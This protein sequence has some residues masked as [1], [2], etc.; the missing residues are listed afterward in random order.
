MSWRDILPIHP[1]ADALPL[2]PEDQLRELG[3]DI[4]KNGLTA[5]PRLYHDVDANTFSLLDGRNRL[6]AMEL[7]GMPDLVKRIEPEKPDRP[8]F[9]WNLPFQKLGGRI[10]E[11]HVP[12]VDS[13]TESFS[14]NSETFEKG[15][16]RRRPGPDPASYVISANLRRRHLRPSE[17]VQQ[18]LAVRAAAG[19]TRP[20]GRVSVGGRGNKGEASEIAAATGVS[21]RTTRRELEKVRKEAQLAEDAR[22][23]N[24]PSV[25]EETKRL[26]RGRYASVWPPLAA[27]LEDIERFSANE[28]SV[29]AAD[30][31][32]HRRAATARR[33]RKLGTYLG[34]I[35]VVL[36]GDA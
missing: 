6:D 23:L 8:P 22:Q 25:E 5:L 9:R 21:L 16:G 4:K 33:L 24:D 31:P 36:E 12:V 32:R 17:L 7:V 28:P 1:A 19:K 14:L 29:V 11:T 2:M 26:I 10:T 20:S 18:A 27:L 34:S 15:T 35:A 13:W 30:V 3:E